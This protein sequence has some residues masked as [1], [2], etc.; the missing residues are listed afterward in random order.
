MSLRRS[1]WLVLVAITVATVCLASVESLSDVDLYWHVLMGQDIAEHGRFTGDPGWTFAPAD[2]TWATTQWASEMLMAWLHDVAGWGGLTALRVAAAGA[3]LTILAGALLRGGGPA[4][5]R[6]AVFTI[7]GLAVAADIEERPAALSFVL[8]AVVGM[9]ASRVLST[10]RWPRWWLPIVLTWVWANLHGYWLLLP[11][12]F[13]LLVLLRLIAK[14]PVRHLRAPAAVTAACV[15]VG[16]L[17]PAGIG[18]VLAPLRV[19]S[20]AGALI[21][22]WGR[23]SLASGVAWAGLALLTVIVVGWARN[24]APAPMA[25]LLW[26]AAWTGFALLAYRNVLPAMLLLAPIAARVLARAFPNESR[27]RPGSRLSLA[28]AA[29]VLAT[30]L[31][32]GGARLV[33]EPRL[34]DWTP[35]TAYAALNDGEHHRVLVAYNL[36]GQTLALTGDRVQVA[37]DGRTD[38]YGADFLRRYQGL[39][40]LHPGWQNTLRDLQPTDALLDR[41]APLHDALVRL[42]W[43]ATAEDG[44]TVLLRAPTTTVW[45]QN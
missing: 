40:A 24:R 14:E 17:T 2:P 43:R 26:V 13:G 12:A 45:G 22:E 15:V 42:G 35:T 23:T 29:V 39:M 31:I 21:E 19:S 18:G 27:T 28:V 30:G 6:A 44:P 9:W 38:R 1:P 37:L 16:A 34:P 4:W 7:V 25:E 32:G 11:A 8:L 33:L 20:A 3:T 5:T 36:S 10:G 41:R